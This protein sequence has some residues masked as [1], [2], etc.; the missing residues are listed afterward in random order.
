MFVPIANLI[1][2]CSLAFDNWPIYKELNYLRQQQHE[3]QRNPATPPQYPNHHLLLG[4]LSNFL[5][6]RIRNMGNL[7]SIISHDLASSLNHHRTGGVISLH[8][9]RHR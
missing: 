1:V 3:G 2:L 7:N 9:I 8:A 6:L 5:L 4:I